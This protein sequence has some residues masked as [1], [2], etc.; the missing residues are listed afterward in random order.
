MEA[1]M[2]QHIVSNSPQR[3]L[4]ILRLGSDKPEAADGSVLSVK[5][6]TVSLNQ[7]SMKSTL[8]EV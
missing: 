6:H 5:R 8:E 4:L 2:I 1:L 3:S 7:H